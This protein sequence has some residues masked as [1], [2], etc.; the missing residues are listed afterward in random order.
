MIAAALAGVAALAVISYTIIKVFTDLDDLD[1]IVV[2]G[3]LACIGSI[4]VEL[5]RP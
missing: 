4:L 3:V 2:M 1:G 5:L